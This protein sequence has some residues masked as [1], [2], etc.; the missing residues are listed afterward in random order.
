MASIIVRAGTTDLAWGAA[1]GAVDARPLSTMPV[2]STVG[3]T[4][5]V[6]MPVGTAVG[7][8]DDA[9]PPVGAAVGDTDAATRPAGAA[10]GD[11]DDTTVPAGAAVGDIDDAL[12]VSF[13]RGA[14]VGVVDEA[15]VSLPKSTASRSASSPST[16]PTLSSLPW[17][18]CPKSPRPLHTRYRVRVRV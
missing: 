11:T 18:S 12:V 16:E 15:R 2:G 14:G 10:V 6:T 7:D 1:V 8:T 4:D 5:D 17:P 3:D 9:T 13:T